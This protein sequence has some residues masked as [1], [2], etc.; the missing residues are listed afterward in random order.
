MK[1]NKK[2]TF[3]TLATLAAVAAPLLFQTSITR[4]DG[5]E[6]RDRDNPIPVA[7]WHTDNDLAAPAP[8]FDVSA[9]GA[10][11]A[12]IGTEVIKGT[13]RMDIKFR[14]PDPIVGVVADCVFTWVFG[15]G[16]L[17][18]HSVCTVPESHGTWSVVSG[19]GRFEN[20]KGIGTQTF[21]P[22]AGPPFTRFERFAGTFTH[23]KHGGD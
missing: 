19:T 15:Q 2:F 9:V 8:G 22:L 21:G 1:I 23:G 5:N 14:P 18:L 16:T 6:R 12:I 4:A 17:V 13:A 7:I 10:V 20:I 11:K 3:A